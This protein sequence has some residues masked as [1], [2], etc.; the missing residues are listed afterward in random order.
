MVSPNRSAV[1]ILAGLLMSV[2]ALSTATLDVF[3]FEDP[4]PFLLRWGEGGD[5]PGE[6]QSPWGIA[7]DRFGDVYVADESKND[8]GKFDPTGA[9]ITSWGETGSCLSCLVSP[10]DIESDGDG[11]VKGGG[12][13]YRRGGVITYHLRQT[14]LSAV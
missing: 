13:L 4:P 7:V 12:N 10:R 5:D 14:R 2:L 11:N 3:A 9:F 6:F 8:V 1:L